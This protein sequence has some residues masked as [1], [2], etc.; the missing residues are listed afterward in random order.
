MVL[1]QRVRK[2]VYWDEPNSMVRRCTW[3]YKGDNENRFSP[4]EENLSNQLEVSVRWCKKLLKYFSKNLIKRYFLYN[5]VCS[6]LL[7]PRLLNIAVNT[8]THYIFWKSI[9][10]TG[11]GLS[12]RK[13]PFNYRRSCARN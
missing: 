3:F 12:P 6:L 7:E 9:N 5:F 1:S 11:A 8:A 4:Y 13:T 2:S 10:G